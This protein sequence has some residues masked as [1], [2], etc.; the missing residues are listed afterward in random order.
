[1]VILRYELVEPPDGQWGVVDDHGNWSGVVGMLQREQ[2]DLSLCL[3]ITAPRL[4]VMDYT[5]VYTNDPLVIISL[6]PK[7]L[8]RYLA[9]VRPLTGTSQ[10]LQRLT[11]LLP[12][13]YE[14]F[15][16]LPRVS[17]SL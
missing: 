12:Q 13:L 7:P 17:P 6:K 10:G 1:M 9:L 16:S 5:R 11:H 4:P 15:S 8:P 14:T 3:T 2:A